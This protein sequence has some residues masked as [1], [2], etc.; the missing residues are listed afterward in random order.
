VRPEILLRA[1][2]IFTW[3]LHSR[4]FGD[5]TGGQGCVNIE[6]HLDAAIK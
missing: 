4:K 6:K 5:A 3:R 2:I 1:M